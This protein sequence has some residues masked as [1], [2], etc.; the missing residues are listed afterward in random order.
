[1][2][3]QLGRPRVLETAMPLVHSRHG[4]SAA[5]AVVA[6]EIGACMNDGATSADGAGQLFW[7]AMDGSLQRG[8]IDCADGTF[9]DRV[10]CATEHR[11]SENRPIGT[12][13]C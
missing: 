6:T 9:C 8:V 5:E 11:E 3:K 13:S 4:Y 7:F 12:D 2:L 10:K 1:M